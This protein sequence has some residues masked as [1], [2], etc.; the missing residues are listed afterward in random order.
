SAFSGSSPSQTAVGTTQS[1]ASIDSL[2]EFTIQ[3]SGYTAEYGRNPGGQVQFT[4][5]SG[6]DDL[7]GAL[8]EYIR[9]EDLDANSFQ[10]DYYKDPKTAER[11]NDFGGFVGG[12]LVVPKLYSGKDKTFYFFSYEGL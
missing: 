7:H 10:N 5:R 1:L 11:Q 6:S 9:N 8:F 12:P 4:T 2:Q 3:T